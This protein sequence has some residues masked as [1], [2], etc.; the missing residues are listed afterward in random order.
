MAAD[1]E[2]TL[3]EEIIDWIEAHCRCP[4]GALVRQPI[5]LMNWQ[6]KFI[7]KIYDNPATTTRRAILSV[8]AQMWKDHIG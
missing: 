1:G 3:G 2:L 7:I 8:P 5:R 6:K 4:E